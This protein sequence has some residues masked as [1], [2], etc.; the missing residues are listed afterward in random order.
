MNQVGWFKE[1]LV[2][3]MQYPCCRCFVWIGLAWHFIS[4]NTGD[5]SYQSHQFLM[6][7]PPAKYTDVT[8][9]SCDEDIKLATL[10]AWQHLSVWVIYQSEVKYLSHEHVM[11]CLH[12]ASPSYL[13]QITQDILLHSN[14][15]TCHR[16]SS[17]AS[18]LCCI[19]SLR[20]MVLIQC[21]YFVLLSENS[22]WILEWVK[23]F[24]INLNHICFIT[25]DQWPCGVLW[26]ISDWQ[27]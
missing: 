7:R 18:G 12:K 6:C 20:V 9:G 5:D 25:G 1:R 21:M 13:I 19:S 8:F 24:I 23:D 22:S 11:S 4:K 17:R 27:Q 26:E 16:Q 15:V 3:R 10:S 2:Q 14:N